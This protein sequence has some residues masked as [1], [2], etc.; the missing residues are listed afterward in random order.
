MKEPI[1]YIIFLSNVHS[2]VQ[3]H[4]QENPKI[5]AREDWSYSSP[6]CIQMYNVTWRNTSLLGLLKEDIYKSSE[7]DDVFFN[8]NC[9]ASNLDF[10][11]SSEDED[12]KFFLEALEVYDPMK[13]QSSKDFKWEWTLKKN[14]IGCFSVDYGENLLLVCYRGMVNIGHLYT[15]W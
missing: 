12:D 2:D 15:E 8:S 1:Y 3:R 13:T 11:K 5:W 10:N 6:T 4:I 14:V 9:E 7:E